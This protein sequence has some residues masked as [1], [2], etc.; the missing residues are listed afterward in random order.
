MARILKARWTNQIWIVLIFLLLSCQG[1]IFNREEPVQLSPTTVHGV[2]STV[3]SPIQPSSTSPAATSIINQPLPTV[4]TLT[5]TPMPAN[6]QQV[7][8]TPE[9][10][11]YFS[12]LRFATGPDREP[13]VSFPAGTEEVFAIWEFTGLSTADRIRRIWFRDDQIWLVREEL[14]DTGRYGTTGSVLDISV[15]DNEGSG[16][17]PATYRLQLYVNDA[18]QQEASFVV[19]RP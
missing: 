3:S 19:E 11:Y 1:S 10:V 6:P 5:G 8:P 4:I 13:R 16:L 18:L 9:P 14:W 12:N 17:P 2:L 7:S 15:Y